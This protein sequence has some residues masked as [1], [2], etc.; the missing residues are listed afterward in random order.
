MKEIR[1][2]IKSYNIKYEAIDGTI[3]YNKEECEKYEMTAKA[4]IKS[5]FLKLIVKESTECGIF[6]V[7]SDDYTTYVVKPVTSE[8]AATI[9]QLY[10]L[11]NQWIATNEDNKRYM[12]RAFD[13]IDRA[14]KEK[15]ILF[16]GENYEGE[17]YIINTRK[18][19]IDDLNS[20]DKNVKK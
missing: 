15:D 5:K 11:D 18:A 9:K 19:I 10:I 20:L 14:L 12:D 6:G 1:E 2:E 13:I 17:I 4:V 8:D 3:F 16:V 7:G